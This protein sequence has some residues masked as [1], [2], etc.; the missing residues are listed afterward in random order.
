MRQALTNARVVLPERVLEKATVLVEDE[1]ILAVEPERLGTASASVVDLE[2]RWLLPGIVDLHSDYV[3]TLS[4]PR[5]GALFPRR[6]AAVQWDRICAMCGITT[7][8]DSL[9]FATGEFGVRSVSGM[10]DLVE[11]LETL[12][13]LALVDH[14]LHLRYEVTDRASFEIVRELMAQDRVD[15]LSFND[16]TPGQGQYPTFESYLNY[17]AGKYRMTEEQVRRKVLEKQEARADAPERMRALRELANACGIPIASHDDDSPRQVAGHAAQGVTIVEFP[18]TL[19]AAREARA[20][21]LKT[22]VGAPNLIRGGSTSG[23]LRAIDALQAGVVDA[24]CSDYL[25]SGMLASVFLLPRLSGC[26]LHEAANLVTLNPARMAG[27]TDRGAI[28]PGLRA[29]LMAVEMCG[30]EPVVAA[31]WVRGR[32][33]FATRELTRLGTADEWALIGTE[34]GA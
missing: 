22:M 7:A 26:P 10:K 16:H 5:P 8:Y 13:P 17:C 18:V 14:R 6:F 21:G 31:T 4:E 15:L 32:Q 24:L 27:M 1:C 34:E 29:D 20:R 9:L 28:R 25:P 33:A 12:K 30:E 2:G 19:E 3:E 23:A 11:A